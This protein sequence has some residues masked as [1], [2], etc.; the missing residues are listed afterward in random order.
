MRPDLAAA[1]ERHEIRRAIEAWRQAGAIDAASAERLRARFPD[2]RRRA[3]LAFRVLFFFFTIVAGLACWGFGA[4]F[5]SIGFHGSFASIP[6]AIWLAVLAVGTGWGAAFA[7]GPQRLRGFGVEEGLAALALGFG[8]A[9]LVLLV[10]DAGL[11]GR[12]TAFVVG[13]AVALVAT[14]AARSWGLAGSGLVASGGLLLALGTLP[15]ARLGWVVAAIVLAVSARHWRDGERRPVAHRRRAVEVYVVALVTL[16]LAAHPSH[17]ASRGLRDLGA[18]FDLFPGFEQLTT[19]FGW[20]VILVLPVLLVASGLARRDRLELALGAVGAL[21]A[22][23]TLV[24]ALDLE[25]PWAVA[26]GSG[27]LLA[28]TTWAL[29]RGFAARPERTWSGFTDR[30]LLGTTTE[31]SWLELAAT[32]AALSPAPRPVEERPAFEGEGG[33]FGGGGASSRF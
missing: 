25:P 27:A 23:A 14:G 29:R 10:D 30:E 22:G 32:L 8:V 1:D 17:V 21:A 26:L 19:G 16:W 7:L 28:G 20:L 12:A 33:E 9:A 13:A 2:D 18:W 31:G 11:P 3:R 5:L 4:S 6:H 15:V 24:D